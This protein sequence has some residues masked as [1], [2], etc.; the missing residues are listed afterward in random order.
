[1][2][3]AKEGR[4]FL[5]LLLV[6]ML[7]LAIGSPLADAAQSRLLGTTT[8]TASDLL[9]KPARKARAARVHC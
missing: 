8:V 9:A 3:G 7:L 6:L 4:G 2:N 5:A 1:M